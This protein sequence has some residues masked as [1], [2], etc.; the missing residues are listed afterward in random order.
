[1]ALRVARGLFRLWLI[2]SVLWFAV[3]AFIAWG[4]FEYIDQIETL[5]TKQ[6]QSTIWRL[7]VV[8]DLVEADNRSIA[9]DILIEIVAHAST[10]VA[11]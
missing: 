10:R 6:R 1:M 2:L 3:V 5:A 4:R 9:G 7:N 8:Q 11:A